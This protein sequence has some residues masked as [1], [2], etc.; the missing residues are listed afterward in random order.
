MTKVSSGRLFE[1][2]A[3]GQHLVHAVPRTLHG[4]DIAL[5]M[6]LTG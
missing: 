2:F 1:D 6:A 4:G 5:Y 3:V